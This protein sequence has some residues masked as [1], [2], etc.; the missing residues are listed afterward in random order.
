MSWRDSATDHGYGVAGSPVEPITTIG[1]APGA[2]TGAGLRVGAIG[3]N[4]QPTSLKA[5][6]APK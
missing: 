4:A 2:E 3:Q 5:R 6:S 1:G